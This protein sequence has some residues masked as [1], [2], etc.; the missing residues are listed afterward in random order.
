VPLNDPM[1]LPRWRAAR[2]LA[3]AA[4]VTVLALGV[5]A[6]YHPSPPTGL[7]D[8][9]EGLPLAEAALNV[10]GH[11]YHFQGVK[12]VR[13]RVLEHLIRRRYPNTI[14][15]TTPVTVKPSESVCAF[16]FTGNFTAG[17]VAGSPSGA[18]GRA[19]IVLVTTDRKLLFSFVLTKLPARFN[20]PFT[21]A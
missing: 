11:N 14:H 3:S 13:P 19:A 15:G 5:G 10:P 1:L 21:G 20:R 6:C 18:A 7:A 2:A 17:Q 4:L 12:L 16:A 8:C 9:Y